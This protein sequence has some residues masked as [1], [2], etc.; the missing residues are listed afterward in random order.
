MA[1]TGSGSDGSIGIW[2]VAVSTGSGSDRVASYVSIRIERI[3]D[4]VATA[5]Y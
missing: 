1:G 2:G 5:R 3:F 4:P